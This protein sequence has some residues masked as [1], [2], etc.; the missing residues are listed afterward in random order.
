MT[1]ATSKSQNAA[2]QPQ[3]R[4]LFSG[5]WHVE[6]PKRGNGFHIRLKPVEGEKPIVAGMASYAGEGPAG[7]YC[8]D[9]VH[10]GVV[11]VQTGVDDVEI[12]RTGC[13]IYAHYMRHAAPT[14][15]RDIRLCASCKHFAAAG[16]SERTFIIDR[17]GVVHHVERLPLDL[18]KWR[19]TD[20]STPDDQTIA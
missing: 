20:N 7:T 10:F 12:N 17:A 19:A 8:R 6:R 16:D 14:T 2:K 3:Q 1:S 13:V 18:R 5:E 9:C 15:R 11:A 4:D